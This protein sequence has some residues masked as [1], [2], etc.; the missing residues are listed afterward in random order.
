MLSPRG[1]A[2][3]SISEYGWLGDVDGTSAA[4]GL[5]VSMGHVLGLVIYVIILGIMYYLMFGARFRCNCRVF[6]A[7][8]KASGGL[9]AWMIALGT[10]G[11]RLAIQYSFTEEIVSTLHEEG[12]MCQVYCHGIHTSEE[13]LV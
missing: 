10:V 7:A 5:L 12:F 2:G 3:S 13:H 6:G 1:I 9:L 8:A 4:I 11:F